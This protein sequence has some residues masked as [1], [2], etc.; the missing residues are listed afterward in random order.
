MAIL[1]PVDVGQ[2]FL[3]PDPGLI[4]IT[5]AEASLK[6]KQQQAAKWA[7]AAAQQAAA[8]LAASGFIIGK[9]NGFLGEDPGAN[10]NLG[11]KAPVT[12]VPTAIV[13]PVAPQPPI[14]PPPPIAKIPK[15]P[16]LPPLPPGPKPPGPGPG[17][18]IG[19]GGA[20]GGAGIMLLIGLALLAS[21]GRR[22]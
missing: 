12:I 9:P 15:L 22:K 21:F 3:A 11:P 1:A 10:L 19:G 18:A 6:L 20:A 14:I 13:K 4:V 16:P 7:N 2:K 17:G 8:K 5:A